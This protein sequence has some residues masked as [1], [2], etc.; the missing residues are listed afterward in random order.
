MSLFAPASSKSFTHSL[1]PSPAASESGVLPFSSA[2]SLFAPASSKSFNKMTSLFFAAMRSFESYSLLGM[3]RNCCSFAVSCCFCL[4]SISSASVN[5]EPMDVSK[6]FSSVC[7]GAL[8]AFFPM[9]AIDILTSSLI[10]FI[11]LIFASI[12]FKS[13][14]E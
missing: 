6:L 10:V 9:S 14:V 8:G 11:S 3:L 4:F 12:V 5:L 2:M 1:C 13:S 7:S